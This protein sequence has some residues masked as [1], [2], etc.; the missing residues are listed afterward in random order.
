MRPG[1]GSHTV[2]PTCA[3]LGRA[4]SGATAPVPTGRPV[5]ANGLCWGPAAML[6]SGESSARDAKRRLPHRRRSY[7]YFDAAPECL[8]GRRCVSNGF[9]VSP[10]RCCRVANGP[11][12]RAA[13]LPICEGAQRVR[14]SIVTSPN[15]ARK[16]QLNVIRSRIVEFTSGGEAR[17][18]GTVSDGGDHNVM[19]TGIV[20]PVRGQEFLLNRYR[21]IP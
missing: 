9:A 15:D 2:S 18:R 12:L 7:G 13:I 14:I 8:R 21:N 11:A 4:M 19:S 3:E 17:H 5:F 20:K 1:S 10:M 6:G 16:W